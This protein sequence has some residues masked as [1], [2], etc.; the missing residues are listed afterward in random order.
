MAVINTNLTSLVSQQSIGRT[1]SSLATSMERL[2]SGLRVNSA[3]DDA[4]GL[5]IGNRMQAQP[6][7]LKHAARNANDG[8]SVS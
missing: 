5:A 6:T 8:R 4:A 7:G 1:S 2:A 3:K